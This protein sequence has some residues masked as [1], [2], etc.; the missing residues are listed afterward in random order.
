[1]LATALLWTGACAP[2]TADEAPHRLGGA[3]TP[4]VVPAADAPDDPVRLLRSSE[5]GWMRHR[6]ETTVDLGDATADLAAEVRL[7][8][9]ASGLEEVVAA[10]AEGLA[11]P[12]HVERSTYGAAVGVDRRAAHSLQLDMTLE[13]PGATVVRDGDRIVVRVSFEQDGVTLDER[14]EVGT[15]PPPWDTRS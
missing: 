14:W 10:V 8:W 13:E 15:G 9:D 5:T 4:I 12:P 11:G 6:V 2:E 1:M 3:A 7:R